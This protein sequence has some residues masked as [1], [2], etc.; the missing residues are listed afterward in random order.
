MPTQSNMRPPPKF[1][2][3]TIEFICVGPLQLGM[4]LSCNVICITN[5]TL[6]AKT[7]FSFERSCQL[8]TAF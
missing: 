4:G 5:E 7:N 1:S 3:D 2:P 6:L 8:E